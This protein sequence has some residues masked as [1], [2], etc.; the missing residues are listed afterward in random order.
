MSVLRWIYNRIGQMLCFLFGPFFIYIGSA[1][2][3]PANQT[4][5]GVG[6][7]IVGLVLRHQMILRQIAKRD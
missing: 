6:L 5:S 2:Y 4:L 7:M 3:A 1:T